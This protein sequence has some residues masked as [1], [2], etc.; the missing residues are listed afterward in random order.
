MKLNEIN[1]PV[2]PETY[3]AS[4]A[5]NQLLKIGEHAIKIQNIINNSP[6]VNEWVNDKINLVLLYKIGSTNYN[7]KFSIASI[8]KFFSKELI[9]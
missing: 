2:Q 5:Q 9:N 6:E 7:C 1:K 3:E 8:Y 4:M